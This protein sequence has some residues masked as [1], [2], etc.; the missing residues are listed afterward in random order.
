M[1]VLRKIFLIKLLYFDIM[2]DDIIV[3]SHAVERCNIPS[4][5]LSS[6]DILQNYGTISGPKD[7][8]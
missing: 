2:V 8:K 7:C 3:D 6:G 4:L 5:I 1:D